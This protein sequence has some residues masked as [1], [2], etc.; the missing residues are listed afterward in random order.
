MDRVAVGEDDRAL[1]AIPQL[2]HVAWPGIGPQF[3][4]RRGRRQQ[5]LLVEIA[6]EPLHE[7]VRQGCHVACAFAQR[8]NDDRKDRK[9]EVEI[10]T[11]LAL[12]HPGLQVTIGGRHDAN[13]DAQRTGA[14]RSFELLLLERAQ[15]LGLQPERQIADLIQEERSPVCRLEPPW[16]PP[17]GFGEGALLV[18]EQLRFKQPVRDGRAP[19]TNFSTANVSTATSMATMAVRP[20]RVYPYWVMYRRRGTR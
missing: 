12:R 14:A 7:V 20:S 1:Q 3:V 19:A 9:P 17:D 4:E 5:L 16:L 8:R 15:D 10:L 11:K 18:P 2:T 6:A 13:I